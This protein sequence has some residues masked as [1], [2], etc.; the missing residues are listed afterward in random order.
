M[1]VLELFSGTG[2][3]GKIC[4]E[5]GYEV[6]SLDLKNADI[7][8]DIMEWNYKQQF[9]TGYFDMIWC[10]PPCNSF[11]KLQDAIK[12]KEEIYKNIN[13]NGLPILKRT[14]EIIE[15]FDPKYYFIENPQTGRMKEFIN[16]K[17]YVDVDYC[18]YCDWGYRKRTRIWTNKSSDDIKPLLCN[19]K[20]GNMIKSGN[21]F[22]HKSN[23]GNSD[24]SRRANGKSTTLTERYR[25]PPKLLLS[26]LK[27]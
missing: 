25:I 19:K 13:D 27:M 10:S 5:L 1:K 9:N 2:S 8:T 21:S 15:Y 12:T 4:K 14:L 11:S 23:C 3:V 22:I 6:V 18:M 24:Q 16:D 17:P 26:L 7:E 20:C